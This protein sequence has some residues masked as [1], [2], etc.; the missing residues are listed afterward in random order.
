MPFNYSL[1]IKGKIVPQE[2]QVNEFQKENKT[3]DK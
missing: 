2:N 1:L 3:T